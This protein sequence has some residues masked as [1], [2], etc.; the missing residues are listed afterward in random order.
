M[1]LESLATA[2]IDPTK[3]SEWISGLAGIVGALVGG[4]ATMVMTEWFNSRNRARLDRE[5]NAE[6]TSA[7]FTRLNHIYSVAR[8]IHEHFSDAIT[9]AQ[10]TQGPVHA[11]TLPIQKMSP[12]VFFPVEQQWILIKI[13]GPSVVNT[14]GSLDFAFNQLLDTVEEYKLR[15]ELLQKSLPSPS[16]ANGNQG[17]YILSQEQ[18]LQIAPDS[19]ALDMCIEQIVPLS[20]GIVT[21]G[22]TALCALIGAK[23][24]P[25]GKQWH[26]ELPDP[27]GKLVTLKAGNPEP[28]PVVS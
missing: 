27:S 6:V 10:G 22:F 26:V 23:A 28:Q 13:G 25:L 24:L 16:Q 9:A 21:D 14:I 3:A 5:R 12:H 4:A 11:T 8:Q 15:R 18:M 2:L 7:T 1:S 19:A 20:N 17:S